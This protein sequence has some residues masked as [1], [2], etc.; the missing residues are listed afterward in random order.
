MRRYLVILALLLTSCSSGAGDPGGSGS[1]TP[2]SGL[3]T[4]TI[5]V[6]AAGGEGELNA[7]E[8]MI[9]AFEAAHPGAKVEFTRL[10][11]QSEHIAKLGTAFA[12]GSPPDVFLLNYRRFGRF[13]QQ[14]VIDPARLPGDP[15]DYYPQTLEAFTLDGTLLCSP[16]NLSS[17]V[18]YYNTDLFEKADVDLP[19]AGWTTDDLK[20]AADAF[21]AKK[22]KSI[23]YETGM[24]TVAPF[25]WI[26]GGD[27]VDDL[28]KPTRITLGTPEAREA[29]TYMK[30][31]LDNGGV[32][33]TDAAAAPAEDRF[34]QGELAMLIDSRRAVP[35]LR[36]AEGLSF[37]V[38]PMPKGTTEATLLASDA[39]C[40]AKKA[41]NPELA[42][43]FTRFAV[44]EVGGT[45][46][47][48][49]GRTVPSL[50][51]LAESPA[52]LAP[53]K[54][55]KSSRV[56]LD[57]APTVRRLPNVAAWNE[58]ESTASDALEQ[59]FAGKQSLD[60]TVAAIEKD[61][62]RLLAAEG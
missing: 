9:E 49:S 47:A 20:K 13:A 61:S 4:G 29:L 21:A 42:H 24:R 26:F 46:L 31:L 35:A 3:P 45:V 12:G 54:A 55:P 1:F 57:I 48:E 25:V 7:L 32:T 62:R 52:F 51:S 50:K 27:V 19:K 33:A 30:G 59:F 28:N 44:G 36:K 60:A 17:S 11:E 53:D 56:W 8:E 34:A 5:R 15:A 18:V 16:Q 40:V 41:K 14:G 39:Y 22:V 38:A 23:G 43:A 6:Q 58:T 10:A 2:P 37:D